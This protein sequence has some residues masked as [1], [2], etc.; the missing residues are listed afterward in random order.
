MDNV[1][2]SN[3]IKTRI[4]SKWNAQKAHTKHNDDVLKSLKLK[5]HSNVGIDS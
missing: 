2:T 3:F 1:R 5:T 4:V